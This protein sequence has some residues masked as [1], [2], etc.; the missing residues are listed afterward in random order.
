MPSKTKAQARLMAAAA[1]NPAFAKKVGIPTSVAKE[2][3]AADK[4]KKFGTGGDV[5]YTYGGQNQIGKQRTRFGSTFGYKNNIPDTNINR[6]V[7]KKE[8]GTV[9]HDDLAADKKLIKRAFGMHDKQLHESKKTNLSKLKKGGLAMKKVKMKETMGP[10]TMAKE[11][12]KGKSLKF[13]E[14]GEQKR[15]HTKGKNLGDAGK[16]LGIQGGARGGSKKAVN[17]APIKMCGGGM[18]KSARG[19]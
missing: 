6:Y 8:G 2:F 3:N 10:R 5:G 13:G 18:K 16:K 7:G 9:K 19:R 14:H 11:V 15:G 4:G 1:H 12:E 17:A